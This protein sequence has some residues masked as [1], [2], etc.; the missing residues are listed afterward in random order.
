MNPNEISIGLSETNRG[1][2]IGTG[3]GQHEN[4]KNRNN[5]IELCTN[6]NDRPTEFVDKRSNIN[7]GNV[8]E[9]D[10][11]TKR[12]I[13]PGDVKIMG[14]FEADVPGTVT[15]LSRACDACGESPVM[16]F[17]W[18]SI[19]DETDISTIENIC[20]Q[21]VRKTAMQYMAKECF[22]ER[23]G[24]PISNLR[25]EMERKMTRAL[26]KQS[27]Q[28]EYKLDYLRDEIIDNVKTL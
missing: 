23:N 6:T 26:E 15:K 18:N 22:A 20:L 27:L 14:E 1:I 17:E 9:A 7:I 10:A 13:L 25:K 11:D 3:A 19:D 28:F 4:F 21:C 5:C 8:F 16:G 24:D 2:F 12:V